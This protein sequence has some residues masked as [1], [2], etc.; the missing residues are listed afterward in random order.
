MKSTIFE[1]DLKK[2]QFFNLFQ[3]NKELFSFAKRERDG[4]RD[5]TYV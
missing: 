1:S 3:L 4:E 5:F 2:K